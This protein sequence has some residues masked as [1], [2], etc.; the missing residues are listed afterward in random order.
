MRA[1][2][3]PRPASL[4]RIQPQVTRIG[5]RPDNDIIV[6]DLG[7]SK[8]HV[9]L[10]RTPVGRYSIINLGNTARTSTAPGSTSR[11]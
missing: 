1:G 4:L 5:R 7:V 2:H 9:E 11:S 3:G 6:H 10:R 8:Q